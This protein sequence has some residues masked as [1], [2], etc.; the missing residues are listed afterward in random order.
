M[1]RMV[2]HSI[3]TFIDVAALST[4]VGVA[5]CLFWMARPGADEEASR[6]FAGRLRRLLMFCLIMLLISSVGNLIQRTMEMSGLGLAAVFP[7]LPAVLFKTHFG[8]IGLLR[9]VG[10][11]LA[12][13]ISFIGR[14][15]L[16]SRFVAV[17]LF[18]AS[19]AIAFSRSATS[20]AADFGDL[21][22]QELSDW[23]H[24]IASSLWGGV[25]VAVAIVFRSSLIAEDSRQQPIVAGIADRFYVLFGPVFSL[26]VI[27][28]LY[29]AWVEVGSFGLLVTTPYGRLLSAKIV[30]LIF[31]T[32]RYIA[33]PQHGQDGSAFITKFLRRTRVEAIVILV[34]L[35]C[36]ALLTHNVTA[37]HL[38]HIQHG[39][40]PGG[41]AVYEGQHEH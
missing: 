37:R 39:M 11:G 15:H 10:I 31:L 5:L 4:M 38:M 1:I 19:A 28:G 3:I 20:H 13:A 26:L 23:L 25:L 18:C 12:L 34:V 32:F 30:L 35:L 21:S 40:T 2:L 9:A 17:I 29:N 6:L 41:H 7:L 33:P 22:L 16:N 36:A 27:S 24:L 14:R 8:K